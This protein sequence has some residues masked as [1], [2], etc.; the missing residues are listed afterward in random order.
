MIA[1]SSPDAGEEIDA[2][3][4]GDV[5]GSGLGGDVG[6]RSGLH[7]LAG[8]EDDDAVGEG[9]GVDG[10]VGDEQADTVEGGE[11]AAEVAAHVAA[12]ADV[13]GGRAVRRAATAVGWVA[14]ARASATR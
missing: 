5:S 10:V 14:S 3:E 7:D 12:G 4:V 8:F 11:V 2:D 13:E 1:P 6:Q 9:V